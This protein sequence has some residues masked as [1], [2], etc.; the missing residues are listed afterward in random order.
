MRTD[1]EDDGKELGTKYNI[2]EFAAKQPRPVGYFMV[3]L[4]AKHIRG[5]RML[6]DAWLL[7]KALFWR[8]TVL[9]SQNAYPHLR[10]QALYNDYPHPGMS[11]P[12]QDAPPIAV[13]GGRLRDVTD[14][15]NAQRVAGARMAMGH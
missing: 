8:S 3:R 4:S 7:P 9:A 12:S 11:D 10:M 13:A 14:Y 15:A 5:R 1:I 2:P 6:S